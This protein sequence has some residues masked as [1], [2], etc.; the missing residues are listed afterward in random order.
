M[1]YKIV[2]EG[3]IK[4]LETDVNQL[5]FEGYQLVGGLVVAYSESDDYRYITYLQ[6]LVRKE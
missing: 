4:V 2:E 5:L 1:S 3:N 6:A